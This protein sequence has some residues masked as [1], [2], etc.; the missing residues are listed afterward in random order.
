MSEINICSVTKGK[1]KS[2]IVMKLAFCMTGCVTV[3]G[4][5]VS[6]SERQVQLQSTTSIILQ[7]FRL[8]EAGRAPE[9]K[10]RNKADAPSA[11]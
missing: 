10:V 6:D 11:H 3:T 1:S 5:S 8:P 9:K 4:A 7:C 2:F